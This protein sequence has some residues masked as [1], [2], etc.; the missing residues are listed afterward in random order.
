MFHAISYS[1]HT[2]GLDILSCLFIASFSTV[3]AYGSAFTFGHKNM[4]VWIYSTQVAL[5]NL[6]ASAGDAGDVRDAGSIPVS[7]RYTEKEM[8]TH[9]SRLAWEIPWRGAWQAK[10]MGLQRL[11]CLSTHTHTRKF[12]FLPAFLPGSAS[13]NSWLLRTDLHLIMHVLGSFSS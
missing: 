11:G 2:S 12:I 13:L 7:G 3:F 4:N 10:S 1:V 8:A 6:G 9:S 5:K